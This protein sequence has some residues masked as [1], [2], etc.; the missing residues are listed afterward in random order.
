MNLTT[1]E[2]T[3]LAESSAGVEDIEPTKI[4]VYVRGIGSDGELA[5][6]TNGV[7]A[8]N[9][10]ALSKISSSS[11]VTKMDAVE[12]SPAI[13]SVSAKASTIKQCGMSVSILSSSSTA[14]AACLAANNKVCKPGEFE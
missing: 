1:D 5:V 10:K 8:A 14:G 7:D 13:F 9:V 4:V 2:I 12:D 3:Q 11:T 6:G